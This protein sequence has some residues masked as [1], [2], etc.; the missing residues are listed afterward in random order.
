MVMPAEERPCG[1]LRH[2]EVGD[3]QH[4]SATTAAV[5]VGGAIASQSTDWTRLTCGALGGRAEQREHLAPETGQAGQAEARDAAKVSRPSRG[6]VSA[7]HAAA[8]VG[9]VAAGP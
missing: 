9:Q 5:M 7:Q 3:E 4:E 1:C 8:E 6:A 2:E